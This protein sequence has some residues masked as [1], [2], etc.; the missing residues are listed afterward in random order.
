MWFLIISALIFSVYSI[1]MPKKLTRI[2][3]FST[4]FFAMTLQDNV[5]IYLDG[6]Y[7]LYG[8]FTKGI[9]W[10]T[11]IAII[12]V[13]PAIITIFLNY[14]QFQRQWRNKLVYIFGWSG[15]AVLYEFLAVKSGYF[16]HNGW[17]YVYSAFSYPILFFIHVI[18]L[19][20][21]RKLVR[22]SV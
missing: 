2:E 9:Q 19:K 8:Y 11:L 4:V 20:I 22:E 13:Y 7:D 14:Y 1:F 16:Y 6:K 5:D 18:V 17:S 21:V 12:G 3:I 10:K 15:L